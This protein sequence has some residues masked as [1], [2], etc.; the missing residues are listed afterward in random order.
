MLCPNCNKEIDNDSR[1]CRYCGVEFID[2]EETVTITE[3]PDILDKTISYIQC[4][5]SS[6]KKNADLR[7]HVSNILKNYDFHY[8]K[9]SETGLQS[10][11][12]FV[13]N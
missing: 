6:M 10:I 12:H 5:E 7:L 9:D 11:N 8:Y 3:A 13:L 1:F 4:L 2:E